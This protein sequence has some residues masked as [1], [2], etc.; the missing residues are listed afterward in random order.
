MSGQGPHT[1]GA[2]LIFGAGG[3]QG[4]EGCDVAGEWFIENVREEL[5]AAN[6]YFYDASK[7]ELLFAYNGTGSPP[8]SDAVVVPQLANFVEL[9]GSQERPIRNVTIRGITV[10]A[11]RPT[12]MDPRGNPSGGDWSL[13]RL[14]AIL[15]E[16]TEGVTVEN[17]F[18]TH[19]DGNA[20]SINGYNRGLRIASN[21]FVNLGQNCIAAWGRADSN[22]GLA[23]NYP[24]GTVVEDNF[25]HEIGHIQ[26]QS[27]FY[28]QAETAKTTIRRNIVFNIPR[29]AINFNVGTHPSPS[30]LRA[31]TFFSRRGSHVLHLTYLIVGRLR[32]RQ[33]DDREPAL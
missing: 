23:G 28:F 31:R 30:R 15:L 22:S 11:S 1:E 9:R 14:G 8:S 16:G 10:R 33:R 4:G 25:A 29:A 18:F 13:E 5:D 17:C 26:K 3:H 27:S 20:V 7:K 32:R 21:E 6:E 24:S 19:L 2:E 12:F